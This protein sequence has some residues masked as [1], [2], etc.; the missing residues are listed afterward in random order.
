M[1]NVLLILGK[2]L[3]DKVRLG[4]YDG[5]RAKF[6][7]LNITMVETTAA[8]L[9]LMPKTDVLMAYAPGCKGVD[10]LKDAPQ[11]KWIQ[12]FT[13]GM[14]GLIDQP[15]LKSDVA[16]TSMKGIHGSP[17]SEAALMGMLAL[18]RHTNDTVRFQQEHSWQRVVPALLHGKTVGIFGIGVIGEALAPRCKALGMRVIGISSSKRPVPDFD[19][20]FERSELIRAVRD[21]DHLVLL[22]PYSKE[23]HHIVNKTVLDAM[24][25]GSFLINVARGGIV[26]E[27]ALMVA[28]KNGPLAAAALDVFSVEPL[29]PEHPLWSMPN[30]FITPHTGGVHM[31]Y[32]DHA[33]PIVEEN[34]RRFLASDF[35]NM[36]NLVPH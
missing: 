25:P 35:K 22:T 31:D 23:T 21:V 1:T 5:L 2:S 15:S 3:A 18:A 19:E 20:M 11:V 28:L 34:M 10:L 8:A 29:T 24:K 30:V 16:V 33:L 27:A 9:P 32:A 36:V 4:Y 26:D 14:D 6:P 12:S 13:T 17:V 7:A